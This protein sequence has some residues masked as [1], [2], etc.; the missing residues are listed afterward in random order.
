MQTFLDIVA[1]D[2]YKKTG[3]Q[4]SD[5]IIVF[6]NKRASLFFN[7]ALLELTDKPIWSPRYT[8]ISELFRQYSTM[9]TGDRIQLVCNLYLSYIE[10]TGA[11]EPLDKF[12]GWGELMLNDFDDIDKH[13]A[14]T[15]KVFSLL[16]NI[17]ELDDV[18]FLTQQQ[19]QVLQR[20]FRNF[21]IEHNTELKKR[22]LQLWNKFY[23]IY[24]N[25]RHRL[26][27]QGVAYEGM[28]YRDIIENVIRD[29]NHSFKNID[30]QEYIFIGFNMLHEV[31]TELFSFFQKN[32]KARFYWDY[33]AYY[34]NGHEAGKYIAQHLRRFPNELDAENPTYH[35]F[36]KQTEVTFLSSPTEE[37]NL[38]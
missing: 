26:K 25:Y 18:E 22:F 6:P 35:N 29:N 15:K 8:T 19:Q 33:D 31:E 4:F 17:H 34:L 14:D 20:F 36:G 37:S 32:S 7:K 28:L 1:K 12:Y 10:V 3:G 11:N 9:E 27:S 38:C 30:K 23:D 5:T 24:N 2:L 13:L 21:S 16:S